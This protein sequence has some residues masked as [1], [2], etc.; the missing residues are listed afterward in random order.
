MTIQKEVLVVV[1]SINKSGHYIIEYLVFIYKDHSTIRYFMNNTITN[2]IV[3]R[4][5]LLLH[6]FSITI[7]DKL[8]KDIVILDLS[9]LTNE[10]EA[11][12]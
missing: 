1:Y 9:R 10:G 8:G 4:C 6:E 7:I 3:T 5:L 12:L 2:G 11:T